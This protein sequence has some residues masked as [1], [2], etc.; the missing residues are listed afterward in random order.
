MTVLITG[1]T[2]TIGRPM[3][4]LLAERGHEVK[5]LTRNPDTADLPK[6]V[7]PV[8]GS[9]SDLSSVEAALE[10]VTHLH[11]ITFTGQYEPLEHPDQILALAKQAGIQHITVLQG[12][13]E[14]PVEEAVKAS[15]IAWTGIAPVEFMSNTLEWADSI[16]SEGVVREGF[17]DVRS[18]IV[19]ENDVAA[20]AAAALIDSKNSGTT[21][22][23]TG[24][25]ALTHQERVDILAEATGQPIEYQALSLDEV[26][27]NWKEEG[28]NQDD[29][30]YFLAMRQNPPEVSYTVLDTVREVAGT[31]PH[32]FK[33]WATENATHFI[34]TKAPAAPLDSQE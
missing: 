23:V 15:G 9:L 13:Y 26:I 5:G 6:G 29:I 19:H 14:G 7:T 33:D 24:P 22:T 27:R 20:V 16:K 8:R 11:L 12:G 34:A 3:T 17:P 2:G 1:A 21:L 4:K 25:E 18:T 32:T 31:E 30:D 10:G 28:Y